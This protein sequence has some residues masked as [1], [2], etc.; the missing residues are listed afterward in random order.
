MLAWP[1]R[2]ER[3]LI[4]IIAP[5]KF[6]LLLDLPSQTW[7][8]AVLLKLNADLIRNIR[9]SRFLAPAVVTKPTRSE[10]Q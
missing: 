1:L 9:K 3:L 7:E 5:K 8:L 4:S 6:F 10:I 2:Q